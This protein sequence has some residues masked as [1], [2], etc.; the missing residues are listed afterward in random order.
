MK[1]IH[2]FR[3]LYGYFYYICSGFWFL[4]FNKTMVIGRER[5]QRELVGLLEKE[6]NMDELFT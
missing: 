5:E 3:W 2:S 1:K 6:I 4:Y